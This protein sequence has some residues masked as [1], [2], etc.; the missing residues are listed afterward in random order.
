MAHF[1]GTTFGIG[2]PTNYPQSPTAL[3]F[4]PYGNQGFGI[5]LGQQPY[6]PF[7][8][9]PYA[10]PFSSQVIGSYG[11]GTLQPQQQILQW[12][13]VV[14]QQLQQLQF[15]QQQ[16]L[17]Q[18]QQLLQVVPVQLQQLQQLIQVVT[19]QVQQFP[20]QSQPF[21]PAASGPIGFGVVPSTVA[22][23]AAGHVM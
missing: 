2:S 19:Q 22:G 14:P 1:A 9:Q 20:Q 18:L 15:Q 6:A 12:L 11:I 5:Q 4:S 13:Q 16:L 7:I 23:Q 21:G 3:G 8:Q 10:Q 17:I